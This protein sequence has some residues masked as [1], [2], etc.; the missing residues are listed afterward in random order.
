MHGISLVYAYLGGVEFVAQLSQYLYC[1]WVALYPLYKSRPMSDSLK[2]KRSSA[3]KEIQHV[4]LA[5]VVSPKVTQPVTQGFTDPSRG[6]AQ[7]GSMGHRA[8]GAPILAP[9][10]ANR[11]L[12][13]RDKVPANNAQLS[14]PLSCSACILV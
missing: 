10:N 5:N 14:T 7:V 13:H 8:A 11:V 1:F 12:C 3:S 6:G 4:C 2:S 9:D